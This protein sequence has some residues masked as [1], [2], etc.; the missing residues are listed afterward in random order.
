MSQLKAVR[1]IQALVF[2]AAVPEKGLAIALKCE[3]GTTRAAEA[4]IAAT[5][6]RFFRDEPEIHSGLLAMANK[7]LHNWNGIHVGDVRVTEILA[8]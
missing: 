7:P 5:L 8:A 2:C 6:A 4:M 1:L 3:D